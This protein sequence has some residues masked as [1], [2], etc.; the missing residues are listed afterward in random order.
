[1]SDAMLDTMRRIAREESARF[2][3]ADVGIVT[4][5]H[6]HASESDS[7]LYSCSVQMR[8]TGIVLKR[9][10]VVTHRVGIANLPEVGALVLVEFIAGEINAPVIIGSLYNNAD[11]PPLNGDGKAVLHLPLGASDSDAAH[12]EIISKDKRVLKI[13]MGKTL[14]TIQD[15][16]PAISIDAAGKGTVT[17][18]TNGDIKVKSAGNLELKASGDLKVEAGGTLTLKGGQVKIN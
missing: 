15:D 5:V 6:P 13:A 8:N 16:D 7:D 4:D 10:P 11:R 17:V 9:V 12:I 2:R 1:V 3:T 14:V 18:G